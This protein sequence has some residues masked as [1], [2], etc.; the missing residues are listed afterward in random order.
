MQGKEKIEEK[1]D[2]KE[3]CGKIKNSFKAYKLFLY[4]TSNSFH[5]FFFSI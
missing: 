4:S 1:V 5:L 2:G 3:K